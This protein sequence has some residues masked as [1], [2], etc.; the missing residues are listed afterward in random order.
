MEALQEVHRPEAEARPAD[1]IFDLADARRIEQDLPYAGAVTPLE[2]WDLLTQRKAKLIDVRT[3]PE[4]KFV[5]SI[6]ESTHIEWRGSD[7]L[8]S[9]MFVNTLRGTALPSETVLL[10]CRS[11][12]RSHQAARAAALAGFQKVYNVLEGFEGQRSH[13]GRRGE[14]DG[15]RRRGLPWVQ[16]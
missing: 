9:A 16:D 12:V 1:V 3:A 4:V 14:I 13:A 15:W 2:A 5:G 11:G 7:H 6:P 8:P 10:I